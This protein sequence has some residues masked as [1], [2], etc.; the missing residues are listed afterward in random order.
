MEYNIESIVLSVFSTETDSVIEILCSYGIDKILIKNF[1]FILG[2]EHTPIQLESI[3][4][5]YLTD[6]NKCISTSSPKDKPSLEYIVAEISK[7]LFAKLINRSDIPQEEI[8][9]R[10]SKGLETSC[11]LNG[12]DFKTVKYFFDLEVL[13]TSEA[14]SITDTKSVVPETGSWYQWNKPEEKLIELSY[15]LK[16]LKVIKSITEF[17]YLFNKDNFKVVRFNS[18]KTELLVLLFNELN[19]KKIIT[20]KG[21]NSKKFTPLVKYGVDFENQVLIKKPSKQYMAS[22]KKNAVYHKE[23]LGIVDSWLNWIE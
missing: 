12:W 3:A 11:N 22:I 16:D 8:L 21:N 19:S 13:H 20:P 9:T 23:L 17:R 15:N 6:V 14:Y 7:G 10:I 4:A 2:R 1:N 5:R 18:E